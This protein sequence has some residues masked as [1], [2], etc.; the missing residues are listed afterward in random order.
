MGTPERRSF[1]SGSAA[2]WRWGTP[3]PGGCTSLPSQGS[4]TQLRW[5]RLLQVRQL[6]GLPPGSV[7]ILLRRLSQERNLWLELSFYS[8][9]NNYRVFNVYGT[10]QAL[11]FLNSSQEE[12]LVAVHCPFL[13]SKKTLCQG[14]ATTAKGGWV[15]ELALLLCRKQQNW[16]TEGW[17]D[18]AL[19]I[20]QPPS[21]WQTQKVSLHRNE[22][23][24]PNLFTTEATSLFCS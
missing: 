20:W 13:S 15:R 19:S 7:R 12:K 18:T 22:T 4:E 24:S 1:T 17:S 6:R 21:H 9:L 14:K 11:A 16:V 3:A 10:I 2:R 23:Q 8:A 5:W